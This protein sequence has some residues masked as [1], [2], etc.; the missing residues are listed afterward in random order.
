MIKGYFTVEAALVLPM[1]LWIYQLLIYIMFYQYDRC[2]LEQDIGI[3]AFRG[4]LLQEEEMEE[5]HFHNNKILQDIQKENIYLDKYILFQQDGIRIRL[6]GNKVSISG[7]GSLKTDIPW[8]VK[9]AYE[10]RKIHPALFI[11]TCRKL[12]NRKDNH[13]EDGIYQESEL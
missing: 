1:V 8:T 5:R 6:D 4:T 7:E 3:L 9:A 12:M 13:A 2:I 10:N 11:R